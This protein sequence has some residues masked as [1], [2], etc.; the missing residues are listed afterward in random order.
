MKSCP[1]RVLMGHRKR[2]GGKLAQTHPLSKEN[3]N[4]NH[5]L[6]NTFLNALKLP[7]SSAQHAFS[8]KI[9]KSGANNRYEFCGT[10][11]HRWYVFLLLGFLVKIDSI[12]ARFNASPRVPL[13]AN[14]KALMV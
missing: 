2:D 3:Q 5:A 6:L 13:F 12:Q 7:G 4:D 8:K 9:H 11:I 1:N 14:H 10:K